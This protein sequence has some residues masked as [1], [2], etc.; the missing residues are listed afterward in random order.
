MDRRILEAPL[1]RVAVAILK[2][3][4]S[5]TA[6][7]EIVADHLVRSNLAGHDSH[8]IGMLPYYV[9]FLAKGLLRPNVPA[10]AVK[11]DGAILM[12]D[13]A[14]GYG[15]RVAREAMAAAIDRCRETG[16]VL[17][18][19][20]SAHH[21]GR[22]GTYGEQALDN[23]FVSIH[24]VNVQ[25]HPPLVAPFAGTEARFGTNPICVAVPGRAET[26]PVLLDMATSRI[27][28]GKVRVAMN[29]AESVAPGNL[30]DHAGNPTGD[31]HVMFTETERGALLPIG[32]P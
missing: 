31:P 11:D 20:R 21:I 5:E 29:K 24:F 2:G 16:V 32:V 22:V 12:F 6:E 30:I 9:R 18:T 4:G 26:D 28:L 10:T 15:Q 1:R 19:V 27:A 17:L 3:G 13:G 25:D 23:G 14:R 8:G 7:A